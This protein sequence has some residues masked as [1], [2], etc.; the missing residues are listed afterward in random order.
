MVIPVYVKKLTEITIFESPDGGK[1]VYSRTNGNTMRELHSVSSEL[2]AEMDR[3]QREQQWMDML[4]MS[5][6]NP[7]LQEAI[8]RAI[9]LYELS[10]SDGDEPLMWHPV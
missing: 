3:V 6:R 4:K 9:V 7:A 10:R 1:T 8:D 2:T 5:E